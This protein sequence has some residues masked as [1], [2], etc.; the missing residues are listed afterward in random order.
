MLQEIIVVEG[1]HD[2]AAVLH[3][4]QAEIIVTGGFAISRAVIDRVRL[5]QERR[6]VIILTDPDYAG[7]QI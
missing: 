4:V 2:K 5:A 1:Q 7:E 6:G 3:A